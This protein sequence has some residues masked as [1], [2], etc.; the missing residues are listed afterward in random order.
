M[1]IDRQMYRTVR[2]AGKEYQIWLV[3]CR[4]FDPRLGA[5]SERQNILIIEDKIAEVTEAAPPEGAAV[6]ACEGRYILPGAHSATNI[7]GPTSSIPLSLVEL[8]T[9]LIFCSLDHC[10]RWHPENLLFQAA[11]LLLQAFHW[12]SHS[13]MQNSRSRN[14]YTP[15]VGFISM[16]TLDNLV[17]Y[18]FD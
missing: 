18:R 4:I 16:A 8:L 14:I 1:Q 11:N 17:H 9:V 10:L 13:L 3:G 7:M 15:C 5:F 12:F 2:K 6:L